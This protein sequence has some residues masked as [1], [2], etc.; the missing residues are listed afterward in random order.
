MVLLEGKGES[1]REVNGWVWE[2]VGT[3]ILGK[4]LRVAQDDGHAGGE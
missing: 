4:I 2:S 1:E 3:K